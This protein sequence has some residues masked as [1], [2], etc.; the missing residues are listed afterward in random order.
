MLK[1]LES[2]H[3][4]PLLCFFLDSVFICLLFLPYIFLSPS[5]MFMLMIFI[6]LEK[7][8]LNRNLLLVV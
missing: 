3:C 7:K 5:T 2:P 1:D 8:I 6:L 4:N